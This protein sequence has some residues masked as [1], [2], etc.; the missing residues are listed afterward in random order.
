RNHVGV[1]L[2]KVH[3]VPRPAESRACSH[4]LHR[5]AYTM[6]SRPPTAA[7]SSILH[8]VRETS[9][10]SARKSRLRVSPAQQPNA[11]ARYPLPPPPPLSALHRSTPQSLKYA[12]TRFPLA[13][14]SPPRSEARSA[15]E[16]S[17]TLQ[18]ALPNTRTATASL[19]IQRAAT[20]T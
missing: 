3:R 14:A 1:C 10:R 20:L 5:A 2:R 12:R 11:S 9:D 16:E 7:P 6:S 19:S 4:P 17:S 15:P 13:P 18:P 8:K